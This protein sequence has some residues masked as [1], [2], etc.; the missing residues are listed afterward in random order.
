MALELGEKI[1]DAI[2]H[3]RE[4]LLLFTPRIPRPLIHLFLMFGIFFI[5]VGGM[6]RI[7]WIY[8]LGILMTDFLSLFSFDARR[9][10]EERAGIG[11]LEHLDKGKMQ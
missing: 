9:G 8:V 10:I 11:E 4:R 7:E 2:S 3:L 6:A 1:A 5:L